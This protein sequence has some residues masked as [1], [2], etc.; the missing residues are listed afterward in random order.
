MIGLQRDSYDN[1]EIA[2]ERESI[3]TYLVF[4]LAVLVCIHLH[5]YIVLE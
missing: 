4:T 5:N 1:E 2:S 3:I